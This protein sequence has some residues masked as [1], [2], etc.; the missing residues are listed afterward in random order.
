MALVLNG[1]QQMLR[2]SARDFLASRAP[3]SH[4]REL[5]DSANADGFSRELWSEMA[6]MGWP[7]ILVPEQ[8]GG[9]DYGFLNMQTAPEGDLSSENMGVLRVSQK[10]FNQY[11]AVGPSLL[12]RCGSQ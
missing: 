7:A 11:S 4:L 8:Y 12:K 10:V 2:D 3:V 5:R 6:D 1:E 9:L